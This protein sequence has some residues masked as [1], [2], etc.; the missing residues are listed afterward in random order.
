M[1]IDQFHANEECKDYTATNQ[2]AFL[3]GDD[4]IFATKYYK[5]Q[6]YSTNLYNIK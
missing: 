6:A 4:N 2:L 3:H 1:A 5:V